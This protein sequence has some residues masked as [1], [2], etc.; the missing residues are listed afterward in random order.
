LKKSIEKRVEE[1]EKRLAPTSPRGSAIVFIRPIGFDG[2]TRE[3][4]DAA[5]KALGADQ[6]AFILP[7]PGD[8]FD[9]AASEKDAEA[10]LKA[11]AGRA[12]VI[13][14]VKVKKP[15]P[16]SAGPGDDKL[17]EN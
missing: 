5:I 2:M 15:E 16:S 4:F 8:S 12:F 9:K 7:R 11:G 1:L 3:D 6:G 13:E 17:Y 14:V 10:R